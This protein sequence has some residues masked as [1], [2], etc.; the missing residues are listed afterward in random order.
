MRLPATGY[1]SRPKLRSAN[2]TAR[3]L[4]RTRSGMR[5]LAFAL[6]VTLLSAGAAWGQH[7][8]LTQR[9]SV[10]RDGQFSTETYLTPSNVNSNQFGSLFSS[11]VDGYV[12]ARPLY[13]S[14]VN[15]PN[16]GVVNVVYVATTHDSVYAFDAVT[17]VQY[18]QVSLIDAS[19]TTEPVSLLGC[20]SVNAY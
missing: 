14:G 18:W 6:M 7:N 16:V 13:V 11:G 10:T 12:V 5:A 1:F 3:Q 20:A 15:I 19:G 2:A 17:G 8:V 9:G 4:R